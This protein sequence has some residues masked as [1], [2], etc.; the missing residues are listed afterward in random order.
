[1]HLLKNIS[2]LCLHALHLLFEKK[3]KK[4]NVCGFLRKEGIKFHSLK[5]TN[6]KSL[7]KMPFVKKETLFS[8]EICK[9]INLC[10][11]FQKVSYF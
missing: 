2:N 5:P 1:M 3:K 7:F 8:L 6:T 9:Y 11:I 10:D 4:K